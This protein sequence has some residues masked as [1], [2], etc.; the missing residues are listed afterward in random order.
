MEQDKT[1][2]PDVWEAFLIIF[3]TS[4]AKEPDSDKPT[5]ETTIDNW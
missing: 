5:S 1:T 2:T 4:S 3:I